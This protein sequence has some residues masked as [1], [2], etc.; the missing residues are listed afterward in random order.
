VI[1]DPDFL[2]HWR[3]GM[4]ADALGDAMAPIYILR[5]WAHCQERKSDTFVMPTRGLKAQCKFPGDAQAFEAALIDAGFI[6][7][8]GD[9]ITVCGWA[10]K[11]A[12][13]LAAWENGSKGGR[14]K[15][16]PGE[17]HGKPMGNP[18]ETHGEPSGNPGE[19]DK[20]R[21]EKNSPS[22]RS[23][24]KT[25]R[26]SAPAAV[27]VSVLVEAGLP[28]GLAGD[29]IAHKDRLK[30]PLT[31]R[32]WRDHCAEAQKAGWS[33]AAAAEKVIAKSWKGFEAR[34]VADERPPARAAPK[35]FAQADA[36]AKAA[37]IYEMT[38]GL[39]GKKPATTIEV[40]DAP[41]AIR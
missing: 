9:S 37:R 19:T 30:A 41:K 33:P 24:E 22:L 10:E 32:A 11:N 18:A 6:A 38:G 8:I 28:E 7:R 34:Y 1:V 4:V 25:A 21:E 27:A 35:S 16:N 23:G 29:F 12:S 31:E 14:P 3:T 5:L 17:T 2:D 36:E 13:L 15:K 20:R 26:K 40:F 39:M